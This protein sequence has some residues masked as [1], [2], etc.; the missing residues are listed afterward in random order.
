MPPKT[1]VKTLVFI[2]LLLI[3]GKAG[4]QR[5]F[6]NTSSNIYEL[7]GGIGSCT[8]KNLGHF[9]LADSAIYSIAFHK[10]TLYVITPTSDLYQIDLNAP[11]TCKYLTRLA[12]PG[13]YISSITCLVCDKNGV[14]YAVDQITRDLYRYDP[15]TDRMDIL[16][17]LPEMPAGDLIFYKDI[18]L[19]TTFNSNIYAV[20]I[21][22]PSA[23]T[24]FMSTPGYIFFGL[25]AVP[26][27]CVKT[28]LFGVQFQPLATSQSTRIVEI[29]PVTGTVGGVVCQTPY[30]ILDAASTIEDGSNGG[31]IID[32]LTV[33]ASCGNDNS[34][35]VQVFASSAA[36]GATTYTLDGI[37]T[38]TTGV[39]PDISVGSH[40]I[41][42]QT[43]SSCFADSIFTLNKGLTNV[44]FQVA[45]PQDCAHPD[46]SIEITG[47]SGSPPILYSLNGG[48]RQASPVFDH[49]TAGGYNISITDAGHCEK[50]TSILLSFQHISP[51]PGDVTVNP[52]LCMKKNGSIAIA[53]AGN[54]DPSTISAS[55]NSGAL[56]SSLS[57]PGLD[58]GS[59]TLHVVSTDGC[60]WDTSFIVQPYPKGAV[61][62]SID[63][64]NPVCTE[65]N[66]G[67]LTIRVQGD[68]APYWLGFNNTTYANGSTI[69]HLSY[70]DYSLS[71]INH[72]GCV[73]D[74]AH[75]HLRLDLRP[76]CDN[77]YIPDAFTPDGNG[78]NDLFRVIHSPYL[79]QI[80]LCVY[81]RYGQLLFASSAERPGWDG[82][83]HGA[84]Q[85]PDTY[86]WTVNYTDLEKRR[87][88]AHGTVL[89]VR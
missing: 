35:S 67:S 6:I 12:I 38:N 7:T 75:V 16:G 81:N 59:Y 54:I 11:G 34:G 32:S 70:G 89:L 2:S 74:S 50:D 20:N 28:R 9:C 63:T 1:I 3:G 84:A 13:G 48:P 88:T 86:V 33:Q 10:D 87:R 26:D 30:N 46:G 19:Y 82:T 22:Q 66:S 78:K 8:Y 5:I 45:D 55:L 52:T 42:I 85:P 24:V 29:D 40:S 79:T 23:S 57:F 56:Q 4:A 77:I 68:Q 36:D 47:S 76:E 27:N 64:V 51:F 61:T 43:S 31:V 72:D 17:V 41:H 15:H 18:L 60:S 21:N 39:F 83:F 62:L 69:G 58:A 49:L 37:L 71:V 14:L 53:L 44:I 65:L 73:V 80:E 25:I